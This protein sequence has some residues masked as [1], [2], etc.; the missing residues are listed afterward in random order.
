PYPP[1]PVFR[2]AHILP[3]EAHL[4]LGSAHQIQHDPKQSSFACA[5][6]SDKPETLR[7]IN[8]KFRHIQHRRLFIA[9]FKPFDCNHSSCLKDE[10]ISYL[11]RITLRMDPF[12][13]RLKKKIPP[14]PTTIK[15]IIP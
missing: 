9:F 8:L 6:I 3:F 11:L 13:K 4:P 15:A 14:I 5:V 12:A 2:S 1:L 7:P 10:E